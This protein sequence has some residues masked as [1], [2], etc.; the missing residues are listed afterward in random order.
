M[1]KPQSDVLRRLLYIVGLPPEL[2]ITL[3][4]K[5]QCTF[6]FLEQPVINFKAATEDSEPTDYSE[7]T[8]KSTLC[9][10]C[11][12]KSPNVLDQH[13]H[14]KS[15]WHNYNLKQKIKGR[16]AVS[17]DGFEKL[18]GDLDESLSGSEL[19]SSDSEDEH[20]ETTLSALLKK[21]VKISQPGNEDPEEIQVG[22]KR[23][24]SGQAGLFK[25]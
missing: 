10:L 9:L 4:F 21:Q 8:S 12:V 7:N 1:A 19:E 22:K 14:A 24:I 17:E 23:N 15:D 13:Q 18:I 3:Q 20:K 25:G 16:P 11:K 6:S 5:D 2:L